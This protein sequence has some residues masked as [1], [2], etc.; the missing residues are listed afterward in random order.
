MNPVTQTLLDQVAD[1][2]IIALVEHWDV[3]EDVVIRV[4]RSR[5]V[6]RKDE[7]DFIATKR[8]L[9]RNHMRWSAALEPYWRRAEIKGLGL[10][11]DDPFQRLLAFDQA[12]DFVGNWN[13]MQLLPAVRQA[14]NEWLLDM[15]SE[16]NSP[17]Y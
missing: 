11:T 7:Q 4:Y 12:R 5:A 10:A 13:A 15:I 2:D 17:A 6:S 9:A 14:I 16:A 8:W 1:P 3:I